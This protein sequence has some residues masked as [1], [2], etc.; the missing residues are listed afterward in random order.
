MLQLLDDTGDQLDERAGDQAA[1][2]DHEPGC[3]ITQH[4][5]TLL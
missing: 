4:H 1:Q 3:W 2:H 5:G